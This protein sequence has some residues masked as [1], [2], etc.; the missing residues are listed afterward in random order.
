MLSTSTR[1]AEDDFNEELGSLLDSCSLLESS[2]HDVLSR[3][4]SFWSNNPIKP[5][6]TNDASHDGKDKARAHFATMLSMYKVK[7]QHKKW[8][9]KHKERNETR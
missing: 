2:L 3:A 1:G 7:L 9:W 4:A 6:Q 8:E 5:H